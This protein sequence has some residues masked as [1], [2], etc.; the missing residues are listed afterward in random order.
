MSTPTT[1]G[2]DDDFTT[3]DTCVSLRSTNDESAGRLD[4]VDGALVEETLGDDWFDDVFHDLFTE[5]FGGDFLGVLGG[6]D[7]GVYSQ[8]DEMARGVLTIFNS[9]LCF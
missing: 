6:D 8:G 3:S 5:V 7:D 4:V 2:V 1:V 9:D